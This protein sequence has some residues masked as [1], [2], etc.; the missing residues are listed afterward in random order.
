MMQFRSLGSNKICYVVTVPST[1]R[2]FF[3]PQLKYLAENGMNISV[4]CST[5]ENFSQN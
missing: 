3:I 4:V 1:I 2:A 5:T